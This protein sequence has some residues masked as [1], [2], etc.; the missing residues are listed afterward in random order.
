MASEE[1]KLDDVYDAVIVGG[2]VAGATAAYRLQNVLSK[3]KGVNNNDGCKVLLLEAKARLGGRTLTESVKVN[4]GQEMFDLGGQWIGRTQH[5]ILWLMKELG[6]EYYEQY[7]LGSKFLC[8]GDGKIRKYNSSLP[9]LSFMALLDLGNVMLQINRM[10]KKVPPDSIHKCKQAEEWDSMTVDTFIRKTMWTKEARETLETA[11]HVIF[12]ATPK[13]LSLLYFLQY[14]NAA[15]GCEALVETAKGG[16]QEFRI[17]GGAQQISEKAAEKIGS[18]NVWLSEPVKL[19]DQSNPD[20]VTI[21]TESGKEVK[22]KHVIVAAPIHCVENIKF[23]PGL[24]MDRHYLAQRMPIG[25]LMKFIVTLKKAFWR[26]AGLSGEVVS[27]GGPPVVDG[28][29]TGPI[30]LVYD[31][32]TSNGS[33]ALVGFFS[34]SRQWRKIEPSV[35]RREVVKSLVDYFGLQADD[36]ID[37]VDKDWA[38]EEYNGGCPVNIMTTGA[39]TLFHDTLREPVDRVH[40]AGTE[41]STIWT[42]YISGA[43]QTGLRAAEQVI[44]KIDPTWTQDGLLD[45]LDKKSL[46]ASDN[47]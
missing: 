36:V 8:L 15:G 2:G 35:R 20:F 31:A 21:V 5:H 22:T 45:S 33:P 6:I 34:N 26:D 13:E 11:I 23:K 29:D 28:C 41:T 18:E 4:D 44:N 38:E 40:W 43:V 12:G 19:I 14:G 10:G 1:N 17:K 24:P 46:V 9:K 32:V 39:M 27:L 30:Q 37:Y 7:T 25:H 42:G 16:A 47:F 3:K